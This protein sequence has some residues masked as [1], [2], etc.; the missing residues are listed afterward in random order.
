[1]DWN[2]MVQRRL[3]EPLGEPYEE[4]LLTVETKRVLVNRLTPPLVAAAQAARSNSCVTDAARRLLPVLFD[5]HR[6]GSDH[7]AKEGYGDHTDRHR[8]PVVR[9]LVDTA[10]TGDAGPL[11]DYVRLFTSNARALDQPLHDLAVL[12]T[13]HA[14]LLSAL[15]RI[16]LQAMRTDLD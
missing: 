15:P 1:G 13:Y 11:T 14:T 9:A 3:P 4:T 8:L 6:R 7:W 10:V 16:C 5:V 2:E 12:F